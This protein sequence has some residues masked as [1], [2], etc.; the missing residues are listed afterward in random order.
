M[1][2]EGSRSSLIAYQALLMEHFIPRHCFAAAELQAVCQRPPI[3]PVVEAAIIT[4]QVVIPVGVEQLVDGEVAGDAEG[5]PA[6]QEHRDC[7][8]RH[9]C[10]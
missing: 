10:M 1:G 3:K 9:L 8:Q 2:H 6:R 7:Q 4:P 5:L